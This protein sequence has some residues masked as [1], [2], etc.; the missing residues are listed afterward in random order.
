MFCKDYEKLVELWFCY[1]DECYFLLK[2]NKDFV[3]CNFFI[4]IC[5]KEMI[6]IK[7]YQQDLELL[8]G[9][10]L[11]VLFLDYYFENLVEWKKQV[12]WVLIYF[13]FCV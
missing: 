7:F 4:I 6:C 9:L 1:V 13:F 2:S 11:D 5:D 10:V 12:C 8:Y 3:D